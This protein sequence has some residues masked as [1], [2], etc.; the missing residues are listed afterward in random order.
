M[1]LEVGENVLPGTCTCIIQRSS[2]GKVAWYVP[3]KLGIPMFKYLVTSFKWRPKG[4]F[5]QLCK[6]VLHLH[7]PKE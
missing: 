7:H 4:V 1:G 2:S 5:I 6:L 3:V